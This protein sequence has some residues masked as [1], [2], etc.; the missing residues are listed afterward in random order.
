MWGPGKGPTGT[1]AL[2]PVPIRKRNA[3]RVPTPTAGA[4]CCPSPA[5]ASHTRAPLTGRGSHHSRRAGARARRH[6]EGLLPGRTPAE[7]PEATAVHQN[8]YGG[9]EDSKSG[10][11]QFDRSLWNG[12]MIA[13]GAEAQSLVILGFL[14][15]QNA[16]SAARYQQDPT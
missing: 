12:R 11:S 14:L 9:R 4:A 7:I 15:A 10:F 2:L 8:I 3:G 6:G 16:T 13:F 1:S 5:L